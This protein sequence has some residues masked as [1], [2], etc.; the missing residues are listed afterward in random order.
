MSAPQAKPGAL[1]AHPKAA[2]A[3]KK[4]MDHSDKS[5]LMRTCS[6]KMAVD[7][8]RKSVLNSCASSRTRRWKGS[9][10]MSS[11]VDFWYLRISRSATVPG[12]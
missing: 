10:R 1:Q 12:L 3:T 8:K 9:L 5:I 2:R 7:W 6:A 4:R 11:S